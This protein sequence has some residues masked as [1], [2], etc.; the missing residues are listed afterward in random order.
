MG[1]EKTFIGQ[2]NGVLKSMPSLDKQCISVLALVWVLFLVFFYLHYTLCVSK[3]LKIYS[4]LSA[5]SVTTLSLFVITT[6]QF[7]IHSVWFSFDL[8]IASFFSP[9]SMGKTFNFVYNFVGGSY[10]VADILD[11]VLSSVM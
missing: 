7:L 8:W 4:L 3:T 1:H 2:E 5:L 6:I 9:E 11:I 10:F